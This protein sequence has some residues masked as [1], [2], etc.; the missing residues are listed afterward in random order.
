MRSAVRWVIVVAA[1]LVVIGL[2]AFARGPEH[3]R[4]TWWLAARL[5]SHSYRSV[6]DARMEALVA[7]CHLHV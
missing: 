5:A 7:A 1:V 2:V 6:S 3:H 4:D